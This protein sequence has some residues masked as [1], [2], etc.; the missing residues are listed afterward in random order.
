M[1]SDKA[2]VGTVAVK[3]LESARKFYEQTLGLTKLME[4]EEVTKET[5]RATGLMPS[6]TVNDLNES[7]TF[8]K[9]LGFQ[10]EPDKR[11]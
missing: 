10:I 4:T 9:T 6:L 7:L 5:L 2:A 8:F 1:L 11:H 3:N